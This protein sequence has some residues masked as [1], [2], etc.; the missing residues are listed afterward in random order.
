[1][2]LNSNR[3]SVDKLINHFW[4]NGYLTVS[5][6]FGTYLPAPQPVGSYNVDAVGRYK[7]K[8]ALGIIL[9]EEE[10]KD[11]S[12]VGKLNFLATRQTKFSNTKVTLF[13]GVEPD[14]AVKAR[15]LI[16]SLSQ[17]AKKNIKL[18]FLAENSITK[19]NTN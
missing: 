4:Q 19:A 1:M 2:A 8:F 13:I 16:G 10:L 7:R 6:K 11:S 15:R 18:V 9:N 14:N 17:D 3:E 5:R 12:A